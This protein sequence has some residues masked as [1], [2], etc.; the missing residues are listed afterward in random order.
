MGKREARSPTGTA[1]LLVT[2]PGGGC[3]CQDH[4]NKRGKNSHVR[5]DYHVS[6]Q[7]KECSTHFP[8]RLMQKETKKTRYSL[9]TMLTMVS[10][11]QK[12]LH[13]PI[14]NV[15][16][17]R[18]AIA[19]RRSTQRAPLLMR[20]QRKCEENGKRRNNDDQIEEVEEEGEREEDE[21]QQ[22]EDLR[23]CAAP[24]ARNPKEQLPS[25][26]LHFDA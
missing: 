12:R 21:K 26:P 19:Q 25:E 13:T 18:R 10:L 15:Q 14:V 8:R 16:G 11:V 7:T 5:Q 1:A 23:G 20:I 22:K 24:C 2:M 17:E 3:W 9:K 6:C 4:W